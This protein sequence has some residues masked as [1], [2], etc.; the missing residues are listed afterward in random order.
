MKYYYK[1]RTRAGEMQTGSVEAVSNEEAVNVLQ[2]RNLIV[3]GLESTEVKGGFK[4]ELRIFPQ[5]V[6]Q[7]DLV[8]FFRQ[9]SILF[10]ANV[11]LV[12]ALNT[13][14]SQVK[15]SIFRQQLFE[16]A[17]EIDGGMSFSAVLSRFPKTFS[18]FA[19]NMIKTG[20]MAGNL[21]KVLD[22]L[23][24][25]IEKDY[26]LTAKIK[27]A[28]FYPAFILGASALLIVIMLTFVMPR[29]FE[30]F[31]EFGADL[32]LPTQIM[33]NATDFF[34]AYGWIVIILLIAFI[35]FITWYL[36]TPGGKAKKDSMEINLPIIGPLLQKIYSARLTENLGTLISGGVNIVQ[37]LDTVSQVIGNVLYEKLLKDARDG[38]RKGENI[39]EIFSNSKLL[40]QTL[41]QMMSSG[42]KSGKLD[43]ILIELTSFYNNEVDRAVSNL[44]S[45]L[46][47][48]LLAIMGVVAAFVAAAVLLPIYNLAGSIM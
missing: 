3:T 38:V 2:Q 27:G 30:M 43:K 8:F 45:L 23:A 36:K 15:S 40:P 21:G 9:L 47:P 12:E 4:K 41:I 10:T 29:M 16:M 33:V 24:N 44:T 31:D 25:H 5:R 11:P 37:A 48:I 17:A 13:L 42:E 14:G 1:A 28:L 18:I 35:A 22:Y 20:E 26:H 39:S 6:S 34:L 32:P 46:E 7:K 19:V